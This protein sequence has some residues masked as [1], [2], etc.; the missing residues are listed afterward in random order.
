MILMEYRW[1]SVVAREM[2]DEIVRYVQDDTMSRKGMCKGDR[3]CGNRAKQSF[4]L[5]YTL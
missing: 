3:W 2:S 1:L 5:E 4:A